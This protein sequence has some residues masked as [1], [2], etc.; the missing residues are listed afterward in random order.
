M[1]LVAI[2]FPVTATLAVAGVDE[3]VALKRETLPAFVPDFRVS[4]GQT[5]KPGLGGFWRF[6]ARL[7]LKND[8]L[9]TV[10]EVQASLLDRNS[11]RVIEVTN[12]VTI[13]LG[14]RHTLQMDG[15]VEVDSTLDE[16]ELWWRADGG[17]PTIDGSQ[18]A[19]AAIEWEYLG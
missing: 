9:P 13:T 3:V 4:A 5:M 1:S 10:T 18:P 14:D 6:T 17:T 8:A 16:F 15:I 19:Y 7:R 12:I 11:N 2:F